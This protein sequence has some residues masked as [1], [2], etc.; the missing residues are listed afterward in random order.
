MEREKKMEMTKKGFPAQG[1]R[2]L[3]GKKSKEEKNWFFLS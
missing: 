2:F 3:G 1:A